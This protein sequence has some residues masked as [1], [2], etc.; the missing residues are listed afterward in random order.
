MCWLTI[1][2]HHMRTDEKCEV[3]WI[4]Q[5]DKKGN[6]LEGAEAAPLMINEQT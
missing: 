2:A 4:Q 5:V 6:P 1:L 3:Y